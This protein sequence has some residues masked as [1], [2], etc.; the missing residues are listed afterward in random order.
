VQTY[1][2]NPRAVSAAYKSEMLLAAQEIQS[3]REK[4]PKVNLPDKVAKPAIK[5][6]HKL[7]IDSLR[8]EIT[9]FE[10]ARAYVAADGREKVT[11]KDLQAVAPMALRLRRSSFMNEYF[12]N[13][14]GEEEEMEALLEMMGKSSR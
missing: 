13:Q 9:W 2:V 5:L 1:L 7:G 11:P 6:V 3:A 12:S 10:A 14:A 4:L 8:A